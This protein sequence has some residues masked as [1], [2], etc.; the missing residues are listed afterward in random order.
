MSDEPSPL[1]VGVDFGTT[2]CTVSVEWM[3]SKLPRLLKFPTHNNAKNN[4]ELDAVLACSPD[5][6]YYGEN[7]QFRPNA[8]LFEHIK[9]AA[10]GR[11]PY[12][13]LLKGAVHE[14]AMINGTSLTIL[15]LF[16]KLFSYIFEVLEEQYPKLPESSVYSMGRPF[17]EIQKACRVTYPVQYNIWLRMMLF[18]AAR[19]AG[20]NEVT[21]VS[22]PLAA[23]HYIA[24]ESERAR[25]PFQAMLIVNSGG[26]STDGATVFFD[27]E[28]E[29]KL[30]CPT[31]GENFGKPS[32]KKASANKYTGFDGGS[33][34]INDAVRTWLQ[35]RLPDNV[36]LKDDKW[37]PRISREIE[38]HKRRFDATTAVVIQIVNESVS[39][40]IEEMKELFQ[41]LI[42]GILELA[43][44]QYTAASENGHPPSDFV[45]TG[46]FARNSWAT[47]YLFRRCKRALRYARNPSKE[48]TMARVDVGLSYLEDRTPSGR[49]LGGD[50]VKDAIGWVI[51]KGEAA[52][53]ESRVVLIKTVYRD[54]RERSNKFISS[55]VWTTTDGFDQKMIQPNTRNDWD[56]PITYPLTGLRSDLNC[57]GIV[58]AKIPHDRLFPAGS[59]H[60]QVEARFLFTIRPRD[61]LLETTVSLI[62]DGHKPL[63]LEKSYV[64]APT[65]VPRYEAKT[66][67]TCTEEELRRFAYATTA[68]AW[69]GASASI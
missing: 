67:S 12:T 40:E 21:G 60:D 3:G 69:F 68:K 57:I 53:A 56:C 44:R 66:K 18:E 27:A 62:C 31:D 58:E 46:G 63:L 14:A 45:L 15:N 23:A 19:K 32:A 64:S 10:M 49:P 54:K 37:W 41:P 28:E 8:V 7:A 29:V 11:K 55:K 5:K 20:F 26:G 36:Y 16:E 13:S 33:Q 6:W 34:V 1:I 43:M 2:S 17:H 4:E 9:L 47:T 22:E 25:L 24:F 42:Q 39:I 51:L 48:V 59:K 65:W 38:G 61:Q 35:Y 52:G 50:R 30:A